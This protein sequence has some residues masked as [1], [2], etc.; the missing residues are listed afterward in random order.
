MR[1]KK[2]EPPKKIHPHFPTRPVKISIR[3]ITI[4]FSAGKRE[5]GAERKS[6]D[7][8]T[9]VFRGNGRQSQRIG[10]RFINRRSRRFVAEHI[11]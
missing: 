6:K 9:Q 5:K 4:N 11:C 3:K 8:R 10:D 2:V 1:K 7:I